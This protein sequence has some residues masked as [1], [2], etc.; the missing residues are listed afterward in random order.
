MSDDPDA[1]PK[2]SAHA[3]VTADDESPAIARLEDQIGWYER[4]SAQN[5]Q[6]FKLLKGVQLVAAAAIPVAATLDAHPALT[7]SLGALIVVVE[8]FQQLNQYQQNW[9]LYRSNAEALKHEKF[10]F[11]ARAGPYASVTDG[12]ALLADRIEGLISQEHAK[13]VSAR[14]EPEE[15]K[16]AEA[17]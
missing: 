9:T 3:T 12:H 7:A 8:G 17:T 4:K 15:R 1:R 10:L 2:S 6:R 11:L 13:W 14:R 5:Q 16:E